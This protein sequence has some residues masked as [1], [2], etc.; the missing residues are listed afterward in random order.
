MVYSLHTKQPISAEPCE[1]GYTL[2][3][4]EGCQPC[5]KD[6]W[7]VAG[8]EGACTKC[9]PGFGVSAGLK[10]REQKTVKRVS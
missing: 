3:P 5:P 10:E 7:S 8:N 4:D 2:V 6:E 9:S 1:A